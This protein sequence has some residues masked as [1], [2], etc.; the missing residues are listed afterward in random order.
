MSRE[1]R[2]PASCCNGPFSRR[3]RRHAVFPSAIHSTT[4]SCDNVLF[5]TDG[6]NSWLAHKRF[7]VMGS[8]RSLSCIPMSTS[9]S[10]SACSRRRRRRYLSYDAQH[11]Y[12][13]DLASAQTTSSG[14][15]CSHASYRE[16]ISNKRTVVI[17]RDTMIGTYTVN[18]K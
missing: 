5:F 9:A 17:P 10:A 12:L 18:V 4:A 6:N 15:C 13:P 2:L 14:K 7:I 3:S 16:Y 8:S 1:T 11:E